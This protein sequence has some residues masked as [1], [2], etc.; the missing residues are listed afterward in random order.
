MNPTQLGM[1]WSP[2][3]ALTFAEINDEN[4][5]DSGMKVLLMK[6]PKTI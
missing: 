4:V 6:T 3:I 2:D 5:I 1:D